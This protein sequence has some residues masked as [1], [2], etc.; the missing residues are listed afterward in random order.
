MK[1][2]MDKQP[3][4]CSITGNALSGVS[5]WHAIF[6]A[7]IHEPE[8]ARGV[9]TKFRISV[10]PPQ[11]KLVERE[12]LLIIQGA[13]TILGEAKVAAA[14]M[15]EVAKKPVKKAAKKKAAKKP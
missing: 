10:L 1:T 2:K 12:V 14:E 7:E 5:K 8:G 4:G 11:A 9:K 6:V 3:Y 15:A 13:Q